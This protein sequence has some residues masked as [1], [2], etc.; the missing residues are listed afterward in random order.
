MD[1]RKE[2]T[3]GTLKYRVLLGK[4]GD[5]MKKVYIAPVLTKLG[6]VRVRTRF[7]PPPSPQ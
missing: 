4:R 5:Q 1:F 2:A 3:A 7:T 6:L